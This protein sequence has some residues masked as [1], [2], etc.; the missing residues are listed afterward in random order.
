MCCKLPLIAS[1][2]G[3]LPEVIGEDGKSGILVPPADPDSLAAAI[4]RLLADELLR[5]KMGEAGRERVERNFTWEKAAKQ[6]LEVY[7]ELL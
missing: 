7:Q 4:K 3:A 6:T 2:A 1:K 5:K